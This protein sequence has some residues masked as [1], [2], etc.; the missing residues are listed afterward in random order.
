MKAMKE[1]QKKKVE[2]EKKE[3]KVEK[4]KKKKKGKEYGETLPYCLLI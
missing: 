3:K 2:K 1:K 4:E